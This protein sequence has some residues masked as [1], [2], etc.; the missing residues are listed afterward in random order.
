MLQGLL[1]LLLLTRGRKVL[2]PSRNPRRSGNVITVASLV[3]SRLT[4]GRNSVKR[5]LLEAG[6]KV[7]ASRGTKGTKGILLQQL[8]VFVQAK[9]GSWIRELPHQ[10]HT[11]S[12]GHEQPEGCSC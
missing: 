3:I 12:A 7:R 10:S 6:I 11:E 5:E 2:E 8:T 4:V 9:P 1:H